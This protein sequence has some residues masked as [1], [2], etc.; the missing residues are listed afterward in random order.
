MKMK[1]RRLDARRV[2]QPRG[3]AITI[4]EHEFSN[5]Y[6][7]KRDPWI[8]PRPKGK[9]NRNGD[10][11]KKHV[12]LR[13]NQAELI[14]RV[15]VAFRARRCYTWKR[16]ENFQAPSARP[17]AFS[18]QSETLTRWYRDAYDTRSSHRSHVSRA[19][20]SYWTVNW[21]LRVHGRIIHVTREYKSSRYRKVNRFWW[22]SHDVVT[23]PIRTRRNWPPWQWENALCK[24]A[25]SEEETWFD[26]SAIACNRNRPFL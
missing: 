4:R 24:L 17:R 16:R 12:P 20:E 5:W 25:R 19:R 13:R 2:N 15:I 3:L 21:R 22:Q 23:Y 6:R 9:K 10:S 18:D 1:N 11:S 8:F 7:Y 14:P 26:W